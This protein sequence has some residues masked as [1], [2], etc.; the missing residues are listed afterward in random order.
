MLEITS[1][2]RMAYRAAP[3]PVRVR[4]LSRQPPGIETFTVELPDGHRARFWGLEEADFLKRLFWLGFE[5]CL[6]EFTR[7]YLAL[8]QRASVVLDLG[9]YLGYYSLLAAVTNSSAEVYSVEPLPDSNA[10]QHRLVQINGV[11]NFHHCPVGVS[12]KSGHVPFFIPDRSL[13]RIP[14]VGSL[15]NRFGP[16]TH[17]SDRDSISIEVETLTLDD[18]VDRFEIGPIDLIKFYI[19]EVETEV[20]TAGIDVLRRWTPDLVGWVFYRD[21]SVE[22]LGQALAELGYAFYAFRGQELVPC[23]VLADAKRLA[24][25]FNPDRGG[26]SAVFM[27]TRPE[28]RINQIASHVPGILSNEGR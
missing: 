28:E 3:E 24:D 12:E 7:V 8:A 17:Y 13:S 9:S 27:T 16:G 10:Y 4:L 1:L 18:L 26:R 6:P 23:P 19:E 21:D 2:C 15:V 22:R 25:V 5:G 11:E 14:N 20:I